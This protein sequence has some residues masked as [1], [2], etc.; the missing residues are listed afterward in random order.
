[1]K[2]TLFAAAA[3][4][5]LALSA[6]AKAAVI[7]LDFEGVG[8]G[9]CGQRKRGQRRCC[10]ER[11]FHKCKPRKLHR[12]GGAPFASGYSIVNERDSKC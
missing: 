10:K 2:K 1:M 3:L 8:V 7:T 9:L 12:T 5:A 11:L 6:Q 4:A